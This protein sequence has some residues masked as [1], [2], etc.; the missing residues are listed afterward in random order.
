MISIPPM[1]RRVKPPSFI[2]KIYHEVPGEANAGDSREILRRSRRPD[3][4]AAL[5]RGA[6]PNKSLKRRG[7]LRRARKRGFR[8]NLG[9]KSVNDRAG[10][11]VSG[12]RKA[13]LAAGLL[14]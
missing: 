13:G 1:R 4:R 10:G 11:L 9:F 5:L 7:P 12:F 2:P 3:G 6:A 14:H 8:K